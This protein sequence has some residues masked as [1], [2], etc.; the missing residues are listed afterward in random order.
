[1]KKNLRPIFSLL[2]AALLFLGCSGCAHLSPGQ[3]PLIV[4]CEQVQKS[5][6]TALDEFLRF[7]AAHPDLPNSVHKVAD[8]IR[9]N[10]P[11]AFVSL[12][13]ARKA[14]EAN[15]TQK[16]ADAVSAI[17]DAINSELAAVAALK[18]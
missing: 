17:L 18:H 1:M 6:L 13:V 4:R 10:G 16:N 3:D 7:D 5:A 14:Y 12:D 11:A 15:K 2:S 8:A 9:D